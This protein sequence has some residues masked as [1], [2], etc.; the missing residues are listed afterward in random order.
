MS[1]KFASQADLEVKKTT[2][3]QLSEHCWAYT[4]EGDPNTG[5]II[6][7]DAPMQVAGQDAWLLDLVGKRFMV[8]LCVNDPAQVN[9][10]LMSAFKMLANGPLACLRCG[11]G[12]DGTGPRLRQSAIRS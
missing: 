2:F 5:V 12:G 10:E 3:A 11:P 8:L 4:A 7:D 6:T 9:A 1:K